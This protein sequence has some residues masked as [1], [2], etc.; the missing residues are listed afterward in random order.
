MRE[1]PLPRRSVAA[2]ALG[3][4][5]AVIVGVYL[6]LPTDEPSR[7]PLAVSLIDAVAWFMSGVVL[8]SMREGKV[9]RSSRAIG[10][11]LLIG[12]AVIALVFVTGLSESNPTPGYRDLLFLL[13]LVTLAIGFR[14]EMRHHVPTGDRREL[15]TDAALIVCALT[16]AGYV[17]IKPP[18]DSPVADAAGVSASA[19]TFALLAAFLAATY[20]AL[21]IW[22]PTRAHVA[23]AGVFAALGAAVLTFGWQWTNSS[24]Q[25]TNP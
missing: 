5:A 14:S 13:P 22:V 25:A 8:L 23:R 11:T 15:A 4:T 19:V 16:A 6:L 7:R 18:L 17:L 1:T 24:Y 21:A 12:S 3:V 2:I 10:F 20:P 9:A